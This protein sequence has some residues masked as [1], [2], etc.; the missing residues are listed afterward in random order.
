[1]NR[2]K[3]ISVVLS[4]VLTITSVPPKAVEASLFSDFFGAIFTII[5]APIWVFCSDNPTFR[6][7]NPFRTQKW[8]EDAAEKTTLE[9]FRKK[10]RIKLPARKEAGYTYSAPISTPTLIS[11]KDASA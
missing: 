9:E 3:L 7:N 8:E 1:M 11:S 5:T 2:K 4:V 10:L 6:K